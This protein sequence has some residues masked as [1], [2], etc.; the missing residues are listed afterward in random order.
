MVENLRP[1][2]LL[3]R[4]A[5]ALTGNVL[6]VAGRGPRNVVVPLLAFLLLR[7]DVGGCS[8]GPARGSRGV[9]ANGRLT[10]KQE[11]RRRERR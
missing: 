7:T 1:P 11:K 8:A 3:E 5:L 9:D 10:V 2:A 6:G 4:T